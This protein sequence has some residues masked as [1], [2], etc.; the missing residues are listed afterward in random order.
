MYI[1]LKLK[2]QFV[3]I[4]SIDLLIFSILSKIRFCNLV[5]CNKKRDF[6]FEISFFVAFAF[7]TASYAQLQYNLQVY[8]LSCKLLYLFNK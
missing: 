8:R 1:I 7:I 4:R 5:K 3:N 6:R 2:Y